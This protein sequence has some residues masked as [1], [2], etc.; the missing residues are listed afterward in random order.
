MFVADDLGAWPVGL[1]ADAGR[2]KLT[3]LVLGSEQER[4]LRQ[5]A[6][7]AIELAAAQLAPSG[8]EQAE[9]LAM[10]VSEVFR[11]PVSAA[12][13]AGQATLL[14][15]AE[16]SAHKRDRAEAVRACRR[17]SAAAGLHWASYN[18]ALSGHAVAVQLVA[19]RRAHGRRARLRHRRWDQTGTIAVQLQRQTS[20]SVADG[21][22]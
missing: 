1:L 2:R 19:R 12:A 5:A 11:G 16:L 4:A 6:I 13:L 10:V 7:A 3:T 14:Q 20:V 8:D 17:R 22:A 21:N 9:Q 15:A 18:M